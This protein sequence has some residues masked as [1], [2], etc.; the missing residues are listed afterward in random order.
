MGGKRTSKEELQQIEALANEG[1]TTREIAERL[2]RS[3]AAIRN[4]RYKKHLAARAKGETE[5]LFQQRDELSSA[6]RA[7]QTQ[8]ASLASEISGL[9]KDKEKLE[10]IIYSDKILLQ[11]T[12]SQALTILKQQRPDLVTLS[13][14]DQVVMFLKAILR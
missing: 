7:L 6:V 2:G 5:L 11:Q 3:P 10:G 13:T 8:K 14:A 1:V 9:K 4:L 12:L